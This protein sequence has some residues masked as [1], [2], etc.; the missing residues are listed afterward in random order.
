MYL[1]PSTC[2]LVS[3]DV[4]QV[5]SFN[6]M[7]L[8]S[9]TNCHNLG[10]FNANNDHVAPRL[11][12]FRSAFCL[13]VYYESTFHTFGRACSKPHSHKNDSSRVFRISNYDGFHIPRPSLS[14]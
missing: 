3:Y 7:N 4:P 14:Y 2:P 5:H 6:E 13:S 9:N 12:K 1:V 11:P 8:S 10:S